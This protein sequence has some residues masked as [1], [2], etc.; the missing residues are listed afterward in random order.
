MDDSVPAPLTIVGSEINL[1]GSNFVLNNV[2]LDDSLVIGDPFTVFNRDV[3]LSGL[4]ADGS[5]FSF[6]LNS[7]E[8]F[9]VDFFDPD[10]TL[11]V[12][13]VSAVPEPGLMPLLAFGS[14][15]LSV[16]RDKAAAV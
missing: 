11:T 4:L 16:R 1:F 8:S 6:D 12:T 13:L 7:V 2:P 10:A 14:L 3:V 5:R 9:N 15:I